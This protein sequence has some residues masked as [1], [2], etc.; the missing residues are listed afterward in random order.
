M[1]GFFYVLPLKNQSQVFVTFFV[2]KS[3]ISKWQQRVELEGCLFQMLPIQSF[4]IKT[5]FSLFR[6]TTERFQSRIQDSCLSVGT[7]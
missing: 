4:F 1:I 3:N 5:N 2:F 7:F 6:R